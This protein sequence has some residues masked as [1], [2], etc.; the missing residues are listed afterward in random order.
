MGAD[1]CEPVPRD[2]NVVCGKGIEESR[3]DC[4]VEKMNERRVCLFCKTL[5]VRDNLLR[6]DGDIRITL[7]LLRTELTLAPVAPC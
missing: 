7:G 2:T 6:W 4:V 3:T 1:A 5:Q